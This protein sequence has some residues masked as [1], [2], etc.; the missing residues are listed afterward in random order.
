MERLSLYGKYPNQVVLSLWPEMSALLR[1]AQPHSVFCVRQTLGARSQQTRIILIW[2]I[3]SFLLR[4]FPNRAPQ[5]C[6]CSHRQ[7]VDSAGVPCEGAEL[8]PNQRAPR[9][10]QT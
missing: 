6:C 7:S 1:V 10:D 5:P 8:F 4:P 2:T 3:F 9:L